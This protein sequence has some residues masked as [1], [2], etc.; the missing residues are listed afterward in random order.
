[1]WFCLAAI[2][3]RFSSLLPPIPPKIWSMLSKPCPTLK[4]QWAG[5]TFC[6]HQILC[7]LAKWSILGTSS[8]L[9][10]AYLRTIQL[11]Q[12]QLQ[13]IEMKIRFTVQEQEATQL[14]YFCNKNIRSLITFELVSDVSRKQIIETADS[15]LGEYTFAKEEK[16]IKRTVIKLLRRSIHSMNSRIIIKGIEWPTGSTV[17]VQSWTR[18]EKVSSLVTTIYAI[19]KGVKH[20]D[21]VNLKTNRQTDGNQSVCLETECFGE[22]LYQLAV[23]NATITEPTKKAELSIKYNVLCDGTSFYVELGQLKNPLVT[24][25]ST[26]KLTTEEIHVY[27]RELRKQLRET[28]RNRMKIEREQR[29]LKAEMKKLVYK[30]DSPSVKALAKDYVELSHKINEYYM[31]V[32]YLRNAEV[33]AQS[34]SYMPFESPF[35]VLRKIQEESLNEAIDEVIESCCD[36]SLGLEPEKCMAQQAVSERDLEKRLNALKVDSSTEEQKQISRKPKEQKE[37][38]IADAANEGYIKIVEYQDVSGKFPAN[39]ELF[40]LISIDMS[41]T[42]ENGKKVLKGVEKEIEDII[43]TLAAMHCLEE[44]YAKEQEV[45]ELIFVKAK[46]WL[47]QRGVAY[48]K[49]KPLLFKQD[50]LHEYG[51]IDKIALF[52]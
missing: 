34:G 30:G 26:N 21:K 13:S 16:D 43:A 52:P 3:P 11:L 20:K 42:M 1:M 9:L 41:E 37:I 29:K 48:E 33:M 36:L 32:H 31:Q 19:V 49:V 15:G 38:I 5:L 4:K 51:F 2:T 27:R 14:A 47:S 44:K 35:S 18:N 39:S 28:E 6:P 8:Y 7:F 24:S 46:L 12:T 25:P 40:K 10:T 50:L 23:K 22:T 45:W 17:I